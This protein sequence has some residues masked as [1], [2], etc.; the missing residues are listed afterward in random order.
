M[1]KDSDDLE[2]YNFEIQFKNRLAVLNSA[3]MPHL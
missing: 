3:I 1:K 2:T